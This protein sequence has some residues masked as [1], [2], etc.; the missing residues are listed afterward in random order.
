[1]KRECS[2]H[3]AFKKCFN[4]KCTWNVVECMSVSSRLNRVCC[5]D[6]LPA[7]SVRF[8]LPQHHCTQ[9]MTSCPVARP[10]Q[11]FAGVCANGDSWVLKTH[12]AKCR[13]S[14][15]FKHSHRD[16]WEPSVAQAWLLRVPAGTSALLCSIEI[17]DRK[18]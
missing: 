2:D 13:N 8:S 5:E 9:R 3:T 14:R 16:V 4:R 15:P 17:T 11:D 7:A 6:N 12:F 10:P 1:M 18:T